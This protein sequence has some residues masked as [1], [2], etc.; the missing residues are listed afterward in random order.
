MTDAYRAIGKPVRVKAESALRVEF[1]NGSRIV[2]LPSGEAT[3]RGFSGV[4]LLV[5]DEAARVPDD[6]YRA[7]RPMLAVSGGRLIALSTPFGRRGWFHRE[8]IE[9]QG[10][11]R[12]KVTA[13]ECPRISSEFLRQERVSLGDWWYRQEYECEFVDTGQSIFSYD[14]VHQAI[15]DTVKPLFD[16]S[17]QARALLEQPDAPEPLFEDASFEVVR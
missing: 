4:D 2:S 14:L 13:E 11:Q 15:D 9:G 8:W 6:L 5:I 3:V 10:W 12:I 7:V 1:A 16:V 17:D